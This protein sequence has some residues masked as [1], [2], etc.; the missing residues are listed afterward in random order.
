[1]RSL[2]MSKQMIERNPDPYNAEPE[3]SALIERFLTPQSLFYVRSHGA[4]PDLPAGHRIEVS[5]IGVKGRSF[6]VEELRAAFKT[7]SVTAVLQ[8]AGNRR[9]DMQQVGKTSGDPW[10][11]GAIGNAEWTGVRLADLLDAVGAPDADDLFVAFTGADEVDVEGEEAPFGISI[12]MAKARAPDV[13]L[14]WAM[15]DEPLAPEHG[16]PLR[17]VVPGYAGV[18]SAKWLTRIEVRD[19][20]SEAPIQAHDYKLFPADVTAETADWSQGLTI[21]AMPLNA[22]IC[23]PGSGESLSA[24]EMRIEGYA[25]AYD[26]RVS[27]VEV[28][29][30]GGRDWCQAT[31][32]DDPE[33]HWGWRRWSLDTT[34][35]KGRQH[36]VVRAFDE[37]GQGQPER[38]DT[39][40]NFAG[41]LCTAWHHVHVLVE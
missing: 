22:A 10:D 40:W 12:A 36:L 15:N 4:V 19:T 24:G 28:S 25:I 1:M 23:S 9:T 7:R 39:M 17:M 27:R 41:Y 5:G 21:N 13:L 35:A 34:L 14:A 6:S 8:C 3:P 2:I 37:A 33:A 32:A 29:T 18:R 30:T 20:P 38:P 16:A 26:R 31:F 11:V